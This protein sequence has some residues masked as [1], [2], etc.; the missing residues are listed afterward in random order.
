MQERNTIAFEIVFSSLG[1]TSRLRVHRYIV[2]V[3]R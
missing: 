3:V 2:V 1:E